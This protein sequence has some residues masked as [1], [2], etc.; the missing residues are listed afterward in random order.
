[1]RPDERRRHRSAERESGDVHWL[2]PAEGVEELAQLAVEHR[3]G[4]ARVGS[5]GPAATEHVI[6]RY[7]E[8]GVRQRG[9]RRVPDV[10]GHG[11]AVHEHDT[12]TVRRARSEE[13]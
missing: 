4:V 10:R 6:T 5:V 2:A 12:R 1:M 7:T 8:A 9:E 13:R 11:E 3:E